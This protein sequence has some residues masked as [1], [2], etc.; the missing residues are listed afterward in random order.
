M[1][2]PE[3]SRFG[4]ERAKT[5]TLAG[6]GDVVKLADAA[7]A[8]NMKLGTLRRL[9]K[10]GMPTVRRADARGGRG[11]TTLLHLPTCRQWLAARQQPGQ[12]VEVLLLQLAGEL[13]AVV[14]AGLDDAARLCDGP[15][16]HA[17]LRMLPGIW[18]LVATALRD[19]LTEHGAPT[20]R[21]LTHAD[22][23]PALARLLNSELQSKR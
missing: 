7:V 8:L 11:S 15:H 2:A 13:P 18:W 6:G 19:H 12:P 4:A 9:V 20:L 22:L 23:P 3:N 10:E 5:G 21:D 16:K 17:L 1:T 14:A